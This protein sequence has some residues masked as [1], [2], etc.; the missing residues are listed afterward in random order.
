MSAITDYSAL[1]VDAGEYSGRADIVQIAPRFLRLLEDK[2]NR[3]LRLGP[4]EVTAPLVLSGGDAAL[5]T[6]FLEAREVKTQA[7]RVLKV[8]AKQALTTTFANY[9]GSPAGYFIVGD[10]ISVRPASDE[11]ITLT[12]Y[13]K[14]PPLTPVDNTNWLLERAPDVYLYGL[15]EEI[16]IWERAADK[17]AAA[18]SMRVNALAGLKLEDERRRFGNAQVVVGGLCP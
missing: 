18:Q 5:P 6:G 12:Y 17:V 16:A 10:T 14:I 15:C 3:V 13:E 2:L 4:M 1:I 8:W 9:G 7:Q 11:T